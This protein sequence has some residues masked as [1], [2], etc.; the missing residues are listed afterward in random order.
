MPSFTRRLIERAARVQAHPVQSGRDW[1]VA[2]W[3]GKQSR[4]L[5]APQT[6]CCTSATT[7]SGLA[8][9]LV[10]E[11]LVVLGQ[12]V[13]TV[14]AAVRRANDAV[15]V[16]PRGFGI[17]ERHTRKG[18]ELDEHDGAVQPVVEGVSRAGAAHP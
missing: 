2:V 6:S 17:V 13:G 5:E 18:L 10:V 12:E 8:A 7:D 11:A 16:V 15:D 1:V 3:D 4:G 9:S 14:V